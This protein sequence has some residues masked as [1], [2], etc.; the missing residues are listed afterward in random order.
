MPREIRRDATGGDFVRLL[1][2]FRTRRQE[3][4]EEEEEMSRL[5]C[6]SVIY[7]ATFINKERQSA[8]FIYIIPMPISGN[9]KRSA[10]IH[11][12]TVPLRQTSSRIFGERGGGER[13]K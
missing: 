1:R 4:E 2:L 7:S 11:V 6:L 8:I 12:K 10:S 9:K 5:C 13:E 3:E